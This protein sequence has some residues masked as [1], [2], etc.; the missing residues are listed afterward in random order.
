M[1]I[2][3]GLWPSRFGQNYSYS[4]DQIENDKTRCKIY[5]R[6]LTNVLQINLGVTKCE[7]TNPDEHI[8]SGFIYRTEEHCALPL[9][10]KIG[11]IKS[12]CTE[13][14]NLEI[15]LLEFLL[16]FQFQT[17]FLCL[18]YVFVWSIKASGYRQGWK[19]VS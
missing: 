11:N 5:E 1:K 9:K 12:M 10:I 8:L 14:K 13:K 7:M 17:P 3:V 15:S 4:C 2:F 18:P 19:V 6:V 16:M